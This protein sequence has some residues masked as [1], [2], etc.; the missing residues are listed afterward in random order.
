MPH[1]SGVRCA[2][3]QLQICESDAAG[4]AEL[5]GFVGAAFARRHGATIHAFM[6]TLLALRGDDGRLCGVAGFR[7]AAQQPLFLEHYFDE[8]IERVLSNAVGSPIGRQQIVEAGNLAGTSCRAACRLVF[9]LPQI[10][11][12]RGHQWLVFTATDAIRKL[13]DAYDAPVI[14]LAAAVAAR[15]AGLGDDWGRYYANDP[16]V[17]AAHLPASVQLRRGRRRSA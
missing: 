4:R 15:V 8:P 6:P 16:R 3:H 12:D 17:L 14:E 7:C 1:H 11:L 13:L 2:G 5:E 10:L 9:E